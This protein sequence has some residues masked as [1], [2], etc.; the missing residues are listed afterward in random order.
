MKTTSFRR[1]RTQTRWK[2]RRRLISVPAGA[3][4]PFR[5]RT[6]LVHGDCPLGGVCRGQGGE[7][8]AMISTIAPHNLRYFFGRF[9][10]Q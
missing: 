2:G 4:L 7:G 1:A 10:L 9:H 6:L 5:E 8:E 3:M